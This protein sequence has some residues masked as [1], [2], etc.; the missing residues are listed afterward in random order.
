M[1]QAYTRSTG[2]TRLSFR[3]GGGVSQQILDLASA[4]G[5]AAVYDVTNPDTRTTRESGGSTFISAIADG[6]GNLPD[7]VQATE[8][9]Q[10][11]LVV[12]RFGQLD[13]VLFDSADQKLVIASSFTELTQPTFRMGLVEDLD[14]GTGFRYALSVTNASLRNLIYTSGATRELKFYSGA[15]AVF[16][17]GIGN[18]KSIVGALF[19]GA[20]SRGYLNSAE[21]NSD[22]AGAEGIDTLKWSFNASGTSGSRWEGHIGLDLLYDGD[23]G[24]AKRQRMFDLIHD[25][26]GIA[27]A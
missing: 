12:G 9:E 6:L 19:N 23:P 27:K 20:N 2:L 18:N 17:G 10:P 15:E 5:W 11:E 24:E 16:G 14:T 13:G 3:S 26:T 1:R 4:D 25:L 22:N 8:A 7:L 21:G